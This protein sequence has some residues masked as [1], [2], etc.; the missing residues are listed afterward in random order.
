MLNKFKKTL[1]SVMIAAV[2]GLTLSGCGEEKMGYLDK[3]GNIPSYTM[4]EAPDGIYILK[5]EDKRVYVGLNAGGVNTQDNTYSTVHYWLLEDMER[6]IPNLTAEDQIIIKNL[7]ERPSSYTFVKMIDY[8]YTVGTNFDVLEDT[9]DIKSPTI[10]TFGSDINENSPADAYLT[11]QISTG[12]YSNENVKITAI[13]GKE[14]TQSMLTEQGYLKGLTKQGMYDFTYYEGTQYKDIMIKADSHLFVAADVYVSSSYAEMEDQYFVVAP[15]SEMSNG[16]YFLSGYGM[17]YYSGA[18]RSIGGD[19][20]K[21]IDVSQPEPETTTDAS[22]SD[23]EEE[24]N[25]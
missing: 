13:N 24:S 14:F 18:E 25:S 8:G 9:S 23:V 15:S 11:S 16:Y 1:T 3:D 12:H 7:G 5:K 21:E 19:T 6:A 2:M 17:F 20:E 10:I 4:D 22:S